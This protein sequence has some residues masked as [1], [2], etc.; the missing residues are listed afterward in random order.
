[1][2]QREREDIRQ[3]EVVG[4]WSE[5]RISLVSRHKRSP[6]NSITLFSPLS[7]FIENGALRDIGNEIAFARMCSVENKVIR[8]TSRL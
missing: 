4:H 6:L 5:I 7:T 8:Q 1:M 3:K 2:S